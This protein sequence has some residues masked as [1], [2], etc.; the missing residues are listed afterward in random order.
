MRLELIQGGNG[1]ARHRLGALGEGLDRFTSSALA[2][3][4]GPH[5]GIIARFRLRPSEFGQWKEG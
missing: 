3:L 2:E 4:A 5:G 1:P